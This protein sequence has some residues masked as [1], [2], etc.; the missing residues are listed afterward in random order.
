[1]ISSVL[2]STSELGPLKRPPLVPA[3]D[4][5]AQAHP[6]LVS[7]ARVH[8]IQVIQTSLFKHRQAV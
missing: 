6:L 4:V 2:N 7:S 5:P 3:V 8:L 1:M